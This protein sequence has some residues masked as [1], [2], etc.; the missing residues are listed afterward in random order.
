MLTIGTAVIRPESSL[1]SSAFMKRTTA[2][3][4]EYSPP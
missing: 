1:V 2:A 4:D 3:I